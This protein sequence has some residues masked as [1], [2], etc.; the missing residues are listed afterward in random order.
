M[1]ALPLVRE[2]EI[3]DPRPESLENARRLL[4]EIPERQYP[5]SF[6]WISHVEEATPGADLC[7]V[8]TQAQGRFQVVREVAGVLGCKRFLVEK[9]V[10]QTTADYRAFLDFSKGQGIE[11]WINCKTRTYPVHKW[12][13]K[14][15]NPE[16]PI[17]FSVMG[18]NYGLG[19][20][21]VHA[22]DLFA[23]YD[24]CSRIENCGG[25]VNSVLHPSKRGPGVF[26]LSGTLS[27]V[28]EKGSH[29]S[30]SYAG[31]HMGPDLV[32]IVTKSYRCL[33]DHFSRWA[34]ECDMN[35]GG[36]W[37]PIPFEGNLLVSQMTKT[38]AMEILST[39]RC[40]LPTLEECWPA[41]EFILESLLPHFNRL[42][43]K[44]DDVCPVT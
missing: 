10:T 17:L 42:L 1:A 40:E 38:F 12:I 15:I 22:A 6:R 26:D 32:S 9:V 27:G 23:F 21:G 14:R 34:F 39:G 5:V 25:A 36:T 11:V 29:V 2:I 4:E 44:N 16:E 24:R 3:V 37:R 18:G 28:S 19:N 20:N 13:K 31:H 43:K 33:V 30:I 7:I 41:H 8:S 35:G